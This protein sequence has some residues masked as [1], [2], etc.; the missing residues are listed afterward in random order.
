MFRIHTRYHTCVYICSKTTSYI[1]TS[2]KE[3]IEAIKRSSSSDT[4]LD[5]AESPS[6]MKRPRLD[7]QQHVVTEEIMV[8]NK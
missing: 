8:R 1:H 7:H 5:L 4:Q 6:L 3:Q 2:C